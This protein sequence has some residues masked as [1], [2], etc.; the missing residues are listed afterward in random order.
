MELKTHISDRKTGISYTL[1]GDY[2][3]PDL[4]LLEE[5]ETCP[6]GRYGRLHGKYIKAHQH[7][8]Y[9]ELLIT[10]KLHSYLVDINEQAQNMFDLLVKQMAEM[11]G[12]N[13]H[14]KA[15]D[16]MAWVGAMNNIRNRAEE[17]VF[18]ELVYV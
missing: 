3:L 5:K 8:V 2:Y 7:I 1:Y 17:L 9:T 14:L 16:Q 11:Q 10:G 4:T 18:K 13:E 15:K 6:V 12:L